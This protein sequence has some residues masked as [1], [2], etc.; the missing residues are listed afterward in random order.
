MI[1]ALREISAKLG[2]WQQVS[3][4]LFEARAPGIA[5]VRIGSVRSDDNLPIPIRSIPGQSRKVILIDKRREEEVWKRLNNPLFVNRLPVARRLDACAFEHLLGKSRGVGVKLL[6]RRN[7][8]LSRFTTLLQNASRQN[9]LSDTVVPY[10]SQ[11]AHERAIK[12]NRSKGTFA[13]KPRNRGRS[14]DCSASSDAG[15]Q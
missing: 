8:R 2:C 7:A 4:E 14:I 5:L 11:P 3:K 1:P 6:A 10:M 9:G 15:M 12:R 13:A